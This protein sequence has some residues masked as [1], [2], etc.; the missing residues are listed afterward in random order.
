MKKNKVN[1]GE[2]KV[3]DGRCRKNYF[4]MA[5]AITAVALDTRDTSKPANP[6]NKLNCQT[7]RIY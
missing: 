7:G 2:Q 5:G 1:F 6:K 4:W 3:S